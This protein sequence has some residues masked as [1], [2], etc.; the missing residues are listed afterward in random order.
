MSCED[1]KRWLDEGRLASGEAACR[2]H[3]ASCPR[4]LAALDAAIELDALLDIHRVP[5][6]AT[7]VEGVMARVA[8]AR[9]GG[10]ALDPPVL[11]WWVRAAAEPSVV[12]A[13]ALAALLIWRGNALPALGAQ[14]VAWLATPLASAGAAAPL[15]LD[16]ATRAAVW[17]TLMIAAP[18]AS[19]LLF[20]WSETLVRPRPTSG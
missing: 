13:L 3:A 14:A 1:V 5:A 10:W 20:R 18:W 7:L 6:P 9:R 11:D 16:P 19:W 17:L 15:A 4:C 12:L 8:V 2:A